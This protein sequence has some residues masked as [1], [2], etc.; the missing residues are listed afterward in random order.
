MLEV[1]LRSGTVVAFDGRVIE[2]F[3]EHEPS[4]R[5]HIGQTGAPEYLHTADGG[6]HGHP[7]ERNGDPFVRPR[8]GADLRTA[9]RRNRRC[10]H[11]HAPLRRPLSKRIAG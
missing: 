11:G 4:R 2:V 10:A 1:R 3:A 5:F 9:H 6:P 8:R 7:R